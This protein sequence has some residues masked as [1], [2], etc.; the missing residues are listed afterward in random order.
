MNQETKRALSFVNDF[1]PLKEP[2]QEPIPIQI[3][4]KSWAHK[5]SNEPKEIPKGK[6]GQG[7]KSV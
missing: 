1:D 2:Y 4:S 6:L 7:G 5:S 3:L